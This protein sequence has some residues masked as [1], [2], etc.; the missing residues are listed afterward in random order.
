[1]I[2][3]WAFGLILIV[4]TIGAVCLRAA[5]MRR[6]AIVLLLNW[7]CEVI[8]YHLTHDSTP[9]LWWM[10]ADT[11]AAIVILTR[12]A[13]R[14]QAYIG[15]TYLIEVAFHSAYGIHL[16]QGYSRTAQMHYWQILQVI[17]YV[18]VALLGGWIGGGLAQRFHRRYSSLYP[19]LPRAP[20]PQGA[21]KT[22]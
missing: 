18:Q 13:G 16:G 4:L 6:T 12:P 2:P 5:P 19:N 14:V 1:M 17:A 11:L 10:A 21:G 20:H 7:A 3:V 8:Y 22:R 9:W 15:A